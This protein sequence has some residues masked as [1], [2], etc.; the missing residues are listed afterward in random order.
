MRTLFDATTH[1][2]IAS[3]AAKALTAQK[4]I[5]TAWLEQSARTK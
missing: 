2:G 4:E 1:T 5:F 3:D